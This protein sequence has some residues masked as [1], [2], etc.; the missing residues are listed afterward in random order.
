MNRED[1]LRQTFLEDVVWYEEID[2]TNSRAL[3]LPGQIET[4]FLIGADAQTTG[5]GRGRNAWWAASGALTFSVVLDPL[6]LG[7][8]PA[9]WPALSL[10]VGLAVCLA[11]EEQVP[12]AQVQLKWPNDVFLGGRKVCGIL[13]ETAA[14]H[15]GR[16]VIGIGLNV[17]NSLQSAAPELQHTATSLCDVLG[18]AADRQQVLISI[19]QQLE[20]TLKSL[21]GDDP[22]L[23]HEWRRRCYLTGYTVQISDV[24]GETTGLCLGVD[25]D[26]ALRLQ[27]SSGPK[28]F[29]SG[30][31]R[32]LSDQPM[33]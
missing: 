4:P 13:I 5:R 2:S 10:T 9:H 27:T 11:L 15:P 24:A 3:Q 22:A 20:R 21:G 33:A 26:A 30:T 31:V 6:L 14:G 17:N 23:L 32:L 29:F 7:V 25:G 8:Q 16:L 28:R 19:L 12:P 1:L 18:E